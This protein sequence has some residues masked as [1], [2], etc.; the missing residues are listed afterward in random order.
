MIILKK[1]IQIK[2]S[3]LACLFVDFFKVAS[4]YGSPKQKGKKLWDGG[5]KEMIAC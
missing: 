1:I 3:D 2:R 5:N 4:A